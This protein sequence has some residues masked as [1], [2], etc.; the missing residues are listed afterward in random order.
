MANTSSEVEDRSYSDQLR[1]PKVK[2]LR[3]SGVNFRQDSDTGGGEVSDT[4]ARRLRDALRTRERLGGPEARIEEV[5]LVTCINMDITDVK[6]L[7]DV[8]VRVL[9]DSQEDHWEP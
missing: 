7:E 6:I 4:F 8:P 2:R 1:L 9:W 3:L 5:S